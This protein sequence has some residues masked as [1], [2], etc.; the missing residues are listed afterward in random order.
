MPIRVLGICLVSLAN[1]A[2]APLELSYVEPDR[3]TPDPGLI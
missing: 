2:V 1:H 3:S